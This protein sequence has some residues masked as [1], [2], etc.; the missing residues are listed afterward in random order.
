ML[1]ILLPL[2]LVS[3]AFAEPPAGTP[4][5]QQTPGNGT[6]FNGWKL[7]PAG[8]HV[9]LPGDMPLKMILSPDGQAA[10]AVCAGYNSPG[11]VV[12]NVAEQKQ[13]QFISIPHIW[14]GLTFDR[15]G[16]KLFVSGGASGEVHVFAYE[17]GEL[18]ALNSVKVAPEGGPKFVSGIAVHPEDGRL[19]VCNEASHEL[20]VLNAETLAVE[21]TLPTGLHPHSCLFGADKR[22]LYVSNWGSRSVSIVDT[23]SG[24]EL[25]ELSVGVRPN[26]MAI[27]PD[28]RLY[29]ACSGDNT[30]HVI[31]TRVL[32]KKGEDA[33]SSRRLW[34]GTREIIS[35]SLYPQSPEGS[36]P[37]ALAVSPDGR[38]LF[39]ANADN[40]CVMVVNI[41]DSETEPGEKYAEKIST[42]EGFIPV[43]WYPTSLAVSSDGGT[44][45]VGNGKGIIDKPDPS[46]D[47][48][49]KPGEKQKAIH[50]GRTLDGSVSFIAKPDDKQ[51]TAYTAQ[52]RKNSPYTPEMLRA[53]KKPNDCVIPD[54]VGASC[55]IK[56]VLYIIKENR[57]YDQV[58]G[59]MKDAKGKPIGNGDPTITLYGE[60]VTPNQHQ[61]SRDYVLLDNLYCNGEVSVDG[62][63]WCDAAMAT[64]WNQR[65]WTQSYSSRKDKL[66]G[67]D[68]L[69]TPTA[70]YL[71][72][73]CKR[74]GISFKTYGEGAQ[75]VPS[76]NRGKWSE[77]R[78]MD[79]CENWIRDLH[80]AEKT[81][82]L[83][84]FT[85]M[86][87]GE[88][89]TKGTTPGQYTPAACVGSND[90]AFGKIVEAATKSKFWKQ[91]A[92]FVIEDDAQNGPDHVDAHRTIGSV[93]S[94]WVKQKSIDHTLY[95]TA[96]MIRTM[97]L[98]LGL[99]PMTQYDAGA[100]PMF[101]CFTNE[102]V[103][104]EYK[105]RQPTVDLLAKNTSASPGAKASAM[106]DF[107]E[108]DEAPEDELNRILWTEAKGP[109][110]PYPAPIHRV[111]FME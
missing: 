71:W 53:V 83:P 44:L 5:A 48:E 13:T 96:S 84:R 62:H 42:V 36:T 18:K 19:Y 88:N 54:K 90:L 110:A 40:N 22:H 63:S 87:L 72:D 89:H 81:G 95:T 57:T 3:S 25:R 45:L 76:V 109:D 60:D 34:D 37:D 100:T 39:V 23:Q 101:R 93:I 1:R 59:D 6:L 65:S 66:P 27:A 26:D 33:D 91:M 70:G 9:A 105:V 11:L 8:K 46:K 77:P 106:M 69:E 29:V 14:N 12:L 97:E 58:L 47:G 64:D 21:A 108:Y 107:D 74:A 86:A 38:T 2:F 4:P 41:G 7:T 79:K 17:A 24:K 75:R 82:E 15:E 67:N 31:Q 51:M 85:I 111:L 55:P 49:L 32:E 20:W 35:T 10:I 102:A 43:G 98:I 30:V 16:K 50:P 61:L 52:V 78:D 68:E 73:Q 28:G 103:A 104:K 56:Y 99:P 92:I 80:E 94:P